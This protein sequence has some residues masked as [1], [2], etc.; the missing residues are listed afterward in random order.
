MVYNSLLD[1]AGVV[2]IGKVLHLV[3][4]GLIPGKNF[5]HGCLMNMD[6]CRGKGAV[7]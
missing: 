4:L 3:M 1:K 5:E 2:R 6:R 7:D